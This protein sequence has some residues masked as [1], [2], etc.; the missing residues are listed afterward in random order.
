MELFSLAPGCFAKR[1]IMMSTTAVAATARTNGRDGFM[2]NTSPW[3][4]YDILCSVESTK[5]STRRL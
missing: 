5:L 3:E 4:H 1:K 2:K